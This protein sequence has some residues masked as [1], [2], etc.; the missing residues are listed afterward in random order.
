M[1]FSRPVR[2]LPA[3]AALPG[4]ASGATNGLAHASVPA[5]PLCVDNKPG[6]NASKARELIKAVPGSCQSQVLRE[7]CCRLDFVSGLG[8]SNCRGG[9]W[10]PQWLPY[11]QPG[12]SYTAGGGIRITAKLGFRDIAPVR[13]A[14]LVLAFRAI[15]NLKLLV[16]RLWAPGHLFLVHLDR[17]ASRR[18]SKDLH[19]WVLDLAGDSAATRKRG[20]FVLQPRLRVMTD[21]FDVRRGGASFLLVLLRGLELLL[22]EPDADAWEYFVNLNDN[23]YPVTTNLA[24]QAF[25]DLH[26]SES[27]VH[28]GSPSTV[29]CPEGALHCRK[30]DHLIVAVECTHGGLYSLLPADE[31]LP[32]WFHTALPLW[33]GPDVVGL[34]RPLAARL[35]AALHEPGSA[36][37]ALLLQLRT[38]QQPD[39]RFFQSFLVYGAGPLGR[40]SHL[41]V[42][43][44]VWDAQRLDP[45]RPLQSAGDPVQIYSPP[46]LRDSAS[47][48]SSLRGLSSSSPMTHFARKFDARRTAGLQRRLDSDARA[49]TA[50]QWL[51]L[52]RGQ[53]WNLAAL[54]AVAR[55]LGVHGSARIRAW[56][57]LA[58]HSA[59]VF[60]WQHLRGFPAEAGSL[61]IKLSERPATAPE[62]DSHIGEVTAVEEA[63][64][65]RVGLLRFVL[66]LRVGIGWDVERL[67]FTGPVSLIPAAA[68]NSVVAAI[69][70]SG[71]PSYRAGIIVEWRAPSGAVWHR[72]TLQVEPSV[73]VA[74]AH[75][76]RRRLSPGRWHVS[77][78][79][80]GP[81]V[82]AHTLR[83]HA[84]ECHAPES[85]CRS[86]STE[87][88]S[89]GPLHRV[90]VS[91]PFEVYLGVDSLLSQC[92]ADCLQEYLHLGPDMY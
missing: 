51:P 12:V 56:A 2:S 64:C 86:S 30:I 81:D 79:W 66:A 43:F 69:Y 24:L 38:A 41:P 46:L 36:V 34:W 42:T 17:K 35:L 47:N 80:E 31:E 22:T 78:S 82:H 39:E 63:A 11:A 13:I 14:F 54:D 21:R 61:A 20:G 50:L 4:I 90:L 9:H 44:H 84:P 32:H 59:T 6:I 45:G 67:Q 83:A 5:G 77:L 33:A 75:C 8:S 74:W 10:V 29:R 53:G 28:I 52:E 70:L 1:L 58:R 23:D 87:P 68:S 55:A 18:Q 85:S 89:A 40:H 76:P 25:L 60:E 26:R 16:K 7:L 37:D 72:S 92:G 65:R 71:R 91:R 27:F 48:H 62:F 15:R 88:P 3:L 49:A 19:R 73:A 57:R